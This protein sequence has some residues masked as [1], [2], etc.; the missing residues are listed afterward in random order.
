MTVPGTTVPQPG[1]AAF[2]VSRPAVVLWSLLL[3]GLMALLPCADRAGAVGTHPAAAPATTVVGPV[4]AGVDHH[5]HGPAAAAD[6][7]GAPL[8]WCTAD[9]RHPVPGSGCSDHPF[10]GPEAQLPNAPP[11]PT[12]VVPARLIAV[13]ALPHG[14]GIGVLSGP[15]HAPDLH[16][17]QVHRS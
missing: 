9:G 3:I 17:L 8:T 12:A 15:D 6:R 11:Q 5:H 7:P 2:A 14:T 4:A 10:C 1:R 16:A 13:Q